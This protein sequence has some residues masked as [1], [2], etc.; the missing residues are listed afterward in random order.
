MKIE[1]FLGWNNNSFYLGQMWL[2]TKVWV[3]SAMTVYRHLCTNLYRK[4]S[5]NDWAK[6]VFHFHDFTTA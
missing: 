4:M 1:L 2:Q 5:A 3:S 6:L